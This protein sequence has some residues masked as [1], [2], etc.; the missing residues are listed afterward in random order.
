MKVRPARKVRPAMKATLFT[1][2]RALHRKK[3]PHTQHSNKHY[4]QESN[5]AIQNQTTASS[6]VSHSKLQKALGG[7]YPRRSLDSIRQHNSISFQKI[8]KWESKLLFITFAHWN[9]NSTP[10]NSPTLHDISFHPNEHCISFHYTN[11]W[12]PKMYF[13]LS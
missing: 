5:Q 2:N 12:S 6:D 13:F 11:I 3:M 4:P 8:S 9:S 7:F 1:K 10:A